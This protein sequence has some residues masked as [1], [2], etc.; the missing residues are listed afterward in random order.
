MGRI[1]GF[2]AVPLGEKFRLL[3][4]ATLLVLARVAFALLP[5]APFRHGLL[6]IARPVA[7]VVPGSP[8]PAHVAWAVDTADRSIPG[9]RT[10]L[11]RS[12]TA[13]TIHRLYDHDIVHRIGVAPACGEDSDDEPA[14]ETGSDHA[15]LE[16]DTPAGFEAHSW[17][18]YDESVLLGHL[19]DLSRFEPLPP[20]NRREQP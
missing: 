7:R 3:V 13:E 10:C 16:A 20:L 9:H 6:V 19:E 12:V 8:S 17:I 2:L 18:E 11:M 1:A 15:S 5:F 4:A 14:S